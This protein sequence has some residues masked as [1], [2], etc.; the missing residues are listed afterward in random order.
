MKIGKTS[1]ILILA[2]ALGLACS[3]A[4]ADLLQYVLSGRVYEGDVGDESTPLNGVM[5]QLYG[6]SDSAEQ[7]S[8]LDSTTTDPMGWYG[9][10]VPIDPIYAYYNIVQMDKDDYFSVGAT[11]APGGGTVKTNNWIQYDGDTL[12]TKTRTGNRFWDR[13][14]QPENSPPTADAGDDQVFV[15]DELPIELRWDCQASDDGLPDP[16]AKLSLTWTFLEGPEQVQFSDPHTVSPDVTFCAYG[17]YV[18]QLEA[19]DG[20]LVVFDN[21]V[22]ELRK[23]AVPDEYD[24]GDAREDPGLG[25][26]YPTL[27]PDGARHKI[28]L[29][30]CLGTTVDGEPDG[31]PHA[32]ALGDDFSPPS[33]DDEDGVMLGPLR[34]GRLASANVTASIDGYLDAWVDFNCNG[35]WADP[36]E[37]VLTA[38]PVGSGLNPLVFQVPSTATYGK[39]TYVRFRFRRKNVPLSYDGPADDGEVEDY[40][41]DQIEPPEYDFGD[42]PTSEQSGFAKSYPTTLAQDGARHMIVDRGPYIG[43]FTDVPDAD[44]DGQPDPNAEGDDLDGNNDEGGLSRTVLC[45]GWPREF[46]VDVD[47]GGGYAGAWI[48]FNGD[49]DWDDQGEEVFQGFLADGA[50]YIEVTAPLG[51]MPITFGRFRLTS[52]PGRLKP[53]GPALDGEVEDFRVLALAA[54]FGD[55]PVPYPTLHADNGAYHCQGI[56]GITLL[57]PRLGEEVDAEPDG[58]PHT[59]ALGD[60]LGP[61]NPGGPFSVDD[62]DGVRFPTRNLIR[63]QKATVEVE[64]VSKDVKPAIV[65][66]WIDFDGDKTWNDR[67]ERIVTEDYWGYGLTRD[68]FQF[69]VPG[70]AK[71]GTTFARFRIAWGWPDPLLNLLPTGYGGV[72]EVED[73][74][75]TIVEAGPPEVFAGDDMVT[76]RPVPLP[77]SINLAGKVTDDGLADPPGELTIRWSVIDGPG[78]VEFEDEADPQTRATFYAY[79]IYRLELVAEDGSPEGP[80]IDDVEI[81]ITDPLG[82]LVAY[83]PFYEGEGT[84]AHDASGYGYHGD[85]IG[86]PCWVAATPITLPGHTAMPI[87]PGYALEFNGNDHVSIN[88]IT[89]QTVAT[90]QVT[91][92]AWVSFEGAPEG[93]PVS[94]PLIQKGDVYQLTAELENSDEPIQS[95]FTVLG[96]QAWSGHHPEFGTQRWH[97]VVGTYDGRQVCLYVDGSL[98]G[99]ADHA[100]ALTHTSPTTIGGPAPPEHQTYLRLAPYRIDEVRMYS[101]ALDGGQVAQLFEVRQKGPR[102]ADLTG[103]GVVDARDLAGTIDL[104]LVKADDPSILPIGGPWMPAEIFLHRDIG[105]PAKA[106]SASYDRGVWTIEA[107]GRDIWDTADEFHYVY[108]A[109]AGDSVLTARIYNP[110]AMDPWDGGCIM[111]RETLEPDSKHAMMVAMP[112]DGVSFQWRP[113]TGGLSESVQDGDAGEVTAPVWLKLERLG[114]TFTGYYSVME[115][116]LADWVPVGSMV[117]PMR[118]EIYV[119]LA[120]TSGDEQ[121]LSR[122]TIDEVSAVIGPGFDLPADLNRDGIVDFRDVALLG[123][124][125]LEEEQGP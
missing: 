112:G 81:Q 118:D 56:G 47:G 66:G 18:L 120:V 34:V 46:R 67:T 23:S 24:F 17:S 116:D 89:N 78:A 44:T 26:H 29:R 83:Y 91:V 52:W 38:E 33:V 77:F 39:Q 100:T 117:I 74:E 70:E 79:G 22:I 35:D 27:L 82:A 113:E 41:V 80:Q 114:D 68:T 73:Y 4:K 102:S 25:Y 101:S 119:G 12:E 105:D 106:G 94:I 76:T 36:S 92:S 14:T 103:D 87:P 28:L 43:F 54:D 15:A 19:S 110:L 11:T 21:V 61:P 55:A 99:S 8:L 88:E 42:A 109:S 45:Q 108:Q 122:A 7:G 32:G 49:G 115:P 93:G 72:G 37:H 65:R 63:G 40:M 51:S 71:I 59:S 97:H 104:W 121:T 5:V 20:E 64:R 85:V 96:G 16:P 84:I 53:T 9:L 2:F 62:E 3:D 75:V 57:G 98:R 1:T 111:L 58:Q 123:S 13:Q 90:G 31:Q 10:D 107:G 95:S 125:W 60:D 6:A 30:V 124:Q 50:H 86:D 48:D 69:Q